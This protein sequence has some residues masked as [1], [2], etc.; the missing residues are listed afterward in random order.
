VARSLYWTSTL[1]LLKSMISS[2]SAPTS[3]DAPGGGL[4][5]LSKGSARNFQPAVPSQLVS[6]GGVIKA[7]LHTRSP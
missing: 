4:M 5:Q 3:F 7:R 1:S 2:D 6:F